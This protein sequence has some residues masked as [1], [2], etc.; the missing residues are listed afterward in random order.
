MI[1]NKEVQVKVK[2][3]IG[4]TKSETLQRIIMQRE[5]FGPLCCSVQ[6]DSFGKECLEKDKLLYSYKGSVGVPPLAM[7]DDLV[8]I[9]ECGIKS[10]LMNAFI[11]AKTNMKK[12]QFG[13]TKCHKMH[14][15][16]KRSYCPELKVDNWD[17]KL[18]D[19]IET[20]EKFI[21][22]EFIG[23][24]KMDE[25]ESEKYLGDYISNRGSNEKNI[26]ERKNKGFGIIKQ[27]MTKLEGTV[28]G[29]FYFEVAL[30]LR[31]SHLL[32]SI[33]TNSEAWYGVRDAEI[34]K[35]EQ[36][37]ETY[38]RKVLEVGT[39]CPKEM[40]YLETG[41]IPI[42]FI[43]KF[44]RL[45]FLHYILNEDVCSLIHR[46]FDAQ[47][48]N[49]SRNDWTVTVEKDLEELDIVLDLEE[50]Q[51]LTSFQFK[52][53]LKKIIAEKALGYLNK[54]KSKH[55]KVLHIT[56]KQL[57]IQA[58]LE[59]KNLVNSQ[60]AKFLFQARSRL[61]E[62]KLKRMSFIVLFNVRNLTLSNIF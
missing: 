50:I 61:L 34:E 39:S 28:Y 40:L 11:N 1:M 47:K 53:F 24:Y 14:I 48:S 54:V 38:L 49:P 36:V 37:D 33:L 7:V 62:C 21:E 45:M 42:R 5:T 13:V 22:D 51:T 52:N 18:V 41:S 12:L 58:Y 15:G 2:T 27:L 4:L 20:G 17:V 8:C 9:S 19:S 35:L 44:R 43:V 59:P 31:R 3:P 55:S 10:V 46:V 23:E 16:A 56:H 32:S 29:P 26:E 60:L 25:S 6:V 30:I 57:K